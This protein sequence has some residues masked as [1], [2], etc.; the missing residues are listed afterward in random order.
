MEIRTSSS[1]NNS[2]S[3]KS[4]NFEGR[5]PVSNESLY[6]R[7]NG[8][9]ERRELEEKGTSIKKD[10]GE[11]HTGTARNRVSL[12]RSS[13][14]SSTEPIRRTKK[15]KKETLGFKTSWQSGP[16]GPER[17]CKKDPRQQGAK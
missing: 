16:G 7:K 17:K 8:S 12:V 11:R 10:Q 14:D 2:S 5:Q 13:P 4:N 1:D 15:C 6:S 9:G 3:Y